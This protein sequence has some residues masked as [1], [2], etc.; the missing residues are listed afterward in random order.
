MT[1][2]SEAVV[3]QLTDIYTGPGRHYHDL[4][5]IKTLL[6]LARELAPAITDG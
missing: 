6:A 3:A 2:L 1:L 4:R 5:H